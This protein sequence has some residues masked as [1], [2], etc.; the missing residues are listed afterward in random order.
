MIERLWELLLEL[1]D[2]AT[3]NFDPWRDILDIAIVTF[4]I[5][6]LLLLMR[7]TRA[8]QILVGMVVLIM[9]SFAADVFS[10]LT[11]QAI[12]SDFLSSAVIIIV[13]LFQHDI[14]RALARV[15]RGFFP[16]VSP[17]Q[18]SQIIEE[19][20]RAA[21]ILSERSVGALIVLERETVLRTISEI[22]RAHV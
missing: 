5:Y 16:A 12:L 15:G 1:V 14:R 11:T 10:L 21:Q 18:E 7:G 2:F 17:Q 20:V 4:A 9:I 13:I 19:V 6:W 3:T 22:G 8:I